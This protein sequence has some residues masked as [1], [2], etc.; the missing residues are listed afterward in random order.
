MMCVSEVWS[1]NV[2]LI[3]CVALRYS[4]LSVSL[5]DFI[6][7][8]CESISEPVVEVHYFYINIYRVTLLKTEWDV[9]VIQETV[10]NELENWGQ[11]RLA[12]FFLTGKRW[13]WERECLVS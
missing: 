13:K 10:F 3:F 4:S 9:F 2:R 6:V 1:A 7:Y 11:C 12:D 8:I 5:P